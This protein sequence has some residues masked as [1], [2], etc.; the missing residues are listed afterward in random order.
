MIRPVIIRDTSTRYSKALAVFERAVP[1]AFWLV[2]VPSM[3][4]WC[5]HAATTWG[6]Q[7]AIYSFC[8]SIFA[9]SLLIGAIGIP[10][11]VL[12]KKHMSENERLRLSY[13]SHR[14]EE[15]TKKAVSSY[16]RNLTQEKEKESGS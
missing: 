4:I 2:V 9:V 12:R 13:V 7:A 15:P 8:V 5:G 11:H 16:T 14:T 10:L 1:I 6:V 3:L